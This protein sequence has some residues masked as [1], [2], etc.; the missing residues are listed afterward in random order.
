VRQSRS[1]DICS[2]SALFPHEGGGNDFLRSSRQYL[3]PV[4]PPP[5][6]R[7]HRHYRSASSWGSVRSE[8]GGLGGGSQRLSPY[9]SPNVSP[10]PHYSDLP[11]VFD[12]SAAPIIVSKQN[13]ATVRTHN[14]RKQEATFTCPVPGCGFHAFFQLEGAIRSHNEE[15][16]FLCK[17][18]GCGKGYTNSLRGWMR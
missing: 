10:A 11:D 14:R 1:E 17:W 2:G 6:I 15:K 5:S 16:P 9:P 7:A 18:P 4:E 13:V 12:P 3:S 8:R